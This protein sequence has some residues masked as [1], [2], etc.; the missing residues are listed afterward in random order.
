MS[1]LNLNIRDIV[2]IIWRTM[3]AGLLAS[4]LIIQLNVMEKVDSYGMSAFSNRDEILTA[5]E[6]NSQLEIPDKSDEDSQ[7]SCVEPYNILEHPNEVIAFMEALDPY[8]SSEPWKLEF[9]K[10][11]LL[12]DKNAVRDYLDFRFPGDNPIN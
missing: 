1:K 12:A 6:T 8:I 4:I 2:T 7:E 10:I 5:I 11:L 9:L 3:I